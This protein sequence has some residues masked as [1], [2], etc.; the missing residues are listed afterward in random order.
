MNRRFLQFLIFS[1]LATALPPVAHA[2]S[3]NQPNILF[4]LVDD[5]GWGDLGVFYQNSRNFA[6]NRNK[7]AFATPKL[8]TLAA[9]GI[10]LRRHAIEGG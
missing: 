6:V 10:Q 4:I 1:T 3:T 5:M 9:E 7:P 8:D 2:A